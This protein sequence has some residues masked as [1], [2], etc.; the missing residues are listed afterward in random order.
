MSAVVVIVADVIIHEASQMLLVQ[1]D[2]M[3]E[4]VAAAVADPAL[5]DAVLPWASETRSLRFDAETL[6][7]LDDFFV[8]LSTAIKD[9]VT[10]CRVV[11]ERLAQ[12]LD[13]PGA[14]R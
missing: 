12:L 13:H 7:R 14:S 6:Y 4:K 2:H 8:E 3:I 9:Q 1:N 11:R 5:G 10:R